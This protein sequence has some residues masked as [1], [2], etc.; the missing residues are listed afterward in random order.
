[1]C[2]ANVRGK[3]VITPQGA[4]QALITHKARKMPRHRIPLYR[5][6]LLPCQN[7]AQS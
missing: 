6:A 5:T 2:A 4:R 1:M 3:R 7:T